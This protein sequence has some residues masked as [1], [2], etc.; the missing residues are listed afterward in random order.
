VKHGYFRSFSHYDLINHISMYIS[1]RMIQKL[2]G[3]FVVWYYVPWAPFPHFM[4]G[5]AFFVPI[6]C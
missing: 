5:A 4:K 3:N 2:A 6:V 1:T